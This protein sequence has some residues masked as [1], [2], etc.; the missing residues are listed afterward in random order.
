[1]KK[2]SLIGILAAAF[3]LLPIS[4]S[5]QDEKETFLEKEYLVVTDTAGTEYAFALEDQPVI[6]F[7]AGNIVVVAS[8]DTLS[9][10]LA[11]IDNY[12]VS[13]RKV[14]TGIMKLPQAANGGEPVLSLSNAAVSGLKAGDRVSIYN[15]N[16]MLLSETVADNSGNASLDMSSLTRGVYILRAPGKSFKFVKK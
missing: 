10:A 6:T 9:T 15:V 16:G 8:G 5:A 7:S 11:G 14:S 1:M 12:K 2:K 4:A 13:T 3:L